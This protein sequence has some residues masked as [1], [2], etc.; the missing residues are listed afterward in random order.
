MRA[1]PNIRAIVVGIFVFIGV[2]IFIITVLTLGSQHN[3]FESGI[4][5]KTFF[6]NV[7]GLQKGNNIWYSGV[8]VGTIKSVVLKEDGNVEVDMGIEE[9]SVKFIPKDVK[10]RLSTDGLI[11]NKIIEIYGGTPAGGRIHEG[12]IVGHDTLV[13]TDEMMKT[14]SKNNDNLYAITSNFKAISSKMATGQG[15][16]GKLFAS[17]TLYYQLNSTIS[18]LKHAAENLNN[19]SANLSAYSSKLSNKNSLA[20]ELVTDTVV[21]RSLRET[22]GRLQNIADSS[23][24]VINNLKTTSNI[25]NHGLENK[26]TPAGM[27]LNDDSTANSLKNILQNLQSASKKLD[28][29]LEAAQH[30]FL[31]RGFFKKKAKAEK[32]NKTLTNSAPVN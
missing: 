27:L 9:N 26:N 7:N 23:Q 32:K 5:I 19:L 14:L 13:N 18:I 25:I 29:D 3:T 15:S 11:G 1:T 20:N 16:L 12:D 31:L 22:M 17:D 30:N 6:N 2:A 4:T 24:R 10:A 28:E 21:F 8:K